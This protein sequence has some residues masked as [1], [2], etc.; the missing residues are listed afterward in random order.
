M[1]RQG[2][3]ARGA[4]DAGHG[5]RHDH[6][7][8]TSERRLLWAM[9]LTAAI[10]L[11]ETAGGLVAGSLALL[12]DAAHMLTDLG[13]LVLAHAGIRLGRRPADPKRSFGYRRLEVLAAFANG[14]ILM[15]LTLWIVIEA[16]QRL[17]QPA[18]V[19][20]GWMLGVAALGLAA[21]LGAYALL[22]GGARESIGIAGAMAHVLGDLLGSIAAIL[23]ATV[24]LATG[25]TP[26]DPLLS[27]AVCT[28]ILRS[29]WDLLRRSGH[30][31]L[32]GTPEDVDPAEVARAASL[33]DGVKAAHHVHVWSLTSGRRI[34][35]LHLKLEDG[36]APGA[37]MAA[38]RTM[39]HEGF[40][41]EHSTIEL[42]I[43]EPDRA[44]CAQDAPERPA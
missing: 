26:I 34:A 12:A 19:L 40:A 28:L 21:N 10:L 3:H 22:R 29:A 37:A 2:E 11:A 9:A 39:L 43:G 44:G 33:I 23:A 18:P 30:I 36:A 38:V 17:Y 4:R 15:A 27:L 5:H 7:T 41:I 25:W 20:G 14:V 24:I 1:H 42:D 35:T 6:A 32:E 16:A 8:E 31:L 13:A